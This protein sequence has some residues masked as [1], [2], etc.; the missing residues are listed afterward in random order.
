MK[1]ASAISVVRKRKIRM[2]SFSRFKTL[3]L[4]LGCATLVIT[5]LADEQIPFEG[6]ISVTA[7]PD[8]L[9]PDPALLNL[10][11][12]GTGRATVVGNILVSALATLDPATLT[13]T[14]SFVWTVSNG[15]QLFGTFEGYFIPTGRPN[16][17][18]NHETFTITGG[19]GRLEGASGGGPAAG[20]GNPFAPDFVVPFSVAISSPG[21]ASH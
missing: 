6:F 15:D 4:S 21:V 20:V 16:V 10:H 18:D 8:P 7:T 3:S 13:Y 12:T 17:F 5:A 9:Q 2:K 11:I 19:T 14:G 1:I